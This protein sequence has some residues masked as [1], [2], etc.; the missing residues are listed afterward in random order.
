MTWTNSVIYAEKTGYYNTFTRSVTKIV[1]PYYLNIVALSR[2]HSVKDLADVFASKLIIKEHI[3][4]VA[5]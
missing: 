2:F 1:F 5:S 4:F 3:D